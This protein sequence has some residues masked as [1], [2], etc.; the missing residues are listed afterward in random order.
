MATLLVKS[1]IRPKKAKIEPPA[2]VNRRGIKMIMT[3]LVESL[4]HGMNA[5]NFEPRFDEE[6][7]RIDSS[8][9]SRGTRVL[10]EQRRVNVVPATTAFKST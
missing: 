7:E 6:I 1:F 3:G 4:P 10:Q 2:N 5:K 8:E 9:L